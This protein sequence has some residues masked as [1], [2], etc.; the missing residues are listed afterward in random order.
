MIEAQKHHI[1]ILCS[2]GVI[3]KSLLNVFGERRLVETLNSSAEQFLLLNEVEISYPEEVRSFKL[4]N[5]I[6][7]KKDSIILN[8]SEI[9]WVERIEERK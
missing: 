3:I 6:I 4:T 9:K 2:D 7:D 1:E 5:R 8:K